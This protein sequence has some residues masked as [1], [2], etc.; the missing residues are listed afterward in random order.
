MYSI[1]KLMLLYVRIFDTELINLLF[2]K[3]VNFKKYYFVIY[4]VK[5][6]FL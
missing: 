2:H 1:V 4:N 5:Q 6:I 3:N